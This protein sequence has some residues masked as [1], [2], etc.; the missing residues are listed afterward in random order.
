MKWLPFASVCVCVCAMHFGRFRIRCVRS[1]FDF[2]KCEV[3][4][5][6]LCCCCCNLALNVIALAVCMCVDVSLV[7]RGRINQIETVHSLCLCESMLPFFIRF[8]FSLHLPLHT[9]TRERTPHRHTH[10]YTHVYTHASD[11]GTTFWAHRIDKRQ[12]WRRRWLQRRRRRRRRRPN[13]LPF[14]FCA[15][16]VFYAYSLSYLH[17]R[18]YTR[19]VYTL[20]YLSPQNSEIIG[21]TRT[22]AC[23]LSFAFAHIKYNTYTQSAVQIE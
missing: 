9:H 20:I 2:G 1:P 19:C 23:V 4:E 7:L 18:K 3:F 17:S 6:I 21:V 14:S 8:N 5:W 11:A 12:A 16:F 13:V 10:T 22:L 15:F